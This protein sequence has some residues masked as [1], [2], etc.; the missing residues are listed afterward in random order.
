MMRKETKEEAAESVQAGRA[1]RR[2]KMRAGGYATMVAALTI[3]VAVAA[4]LMVSN[5]SASMTKWDMTENGVYTL[6]EHLSYCA[7]RCGGLHFGEV[8]GSVQ[9]AFAQH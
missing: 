3:A 4:N 7:K 2:R 1:A 9:R 8:L 5:L 6:S